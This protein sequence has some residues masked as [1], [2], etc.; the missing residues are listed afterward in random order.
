[1]REWQLHGIAVVDDGVYEARFRSGDDERV[2]RFIARPVSVGAEEALAFV[3]DEIE[4]ETL[5][6]RPALKAVTAAVAAFH[7]ARQQ[8]AV[9]A[10]PG[11][12]PL[13][14]PSSP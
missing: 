14:P 8:P 7:R 6:S 4:A 2:F 3:A 1:M 11:Q 12:P 10:P 13:V 5:Y 9:F